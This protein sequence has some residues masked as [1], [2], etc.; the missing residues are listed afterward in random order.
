MSRAGS[1]ASGLE[2]VSCLLLGNAQP[3]GLVSSESMIRAFDLSSSA[4]CKFPGRL[5]HTEAYLVLLRAGMLALT[6]LP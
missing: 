2:K 4:N 6:C 3:F 1:A 5:V